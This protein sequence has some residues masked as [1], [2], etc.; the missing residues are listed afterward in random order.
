MNAVLWLLKVRRVLSPAYFNTHPESHVPFLDLKGDISG[1]L[2][3]GPK[4]H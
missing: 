3:A 1:S 4:A 2:D